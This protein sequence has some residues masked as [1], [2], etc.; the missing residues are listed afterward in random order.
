MCPVVVPSC[1]GGQTSFSFSAFENKCRRAAAAVQY[2]YVG[3]S[4]EPEEVCAVRNSFCSS[5][6]VVSQGGFRLRV[7]LLDFLTN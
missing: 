7:F 3:I 1:F 2:L 4:R 6:Y 5:F